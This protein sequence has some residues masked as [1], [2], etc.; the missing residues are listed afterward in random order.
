LHAI[1]RRRASAFD[2][3]GTGMS[4]DTDADPANYEIATGN[5]TLADLAE[6]RPIVAY[7]FPTAFGMAPPD[8]SGRTV[9][10]YADVRSV[11]G[12]GWGAAGTLRPFLSLGPDG[13]VLNN[14]ND[15]IDVRHYIKHGPVLIDLTALDSDTTIVA[16]ETGRKLFSIATADSLRQYSEFGDFVADL[17]SSLNGSNSARSMYARGYYDVE[18]NVLTAYKIGIYLLEP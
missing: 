2:F 16:R 8:F 7:G 14:Q 1:D 6:G 13:I 5:L 12:I 10:D 17:A 9:I 3:T 11:L 4:F 18:S 15:D